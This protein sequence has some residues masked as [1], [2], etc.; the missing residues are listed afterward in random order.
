M[1]EDKN[2]PQMQSMQSLKIGEYVIVFSVEAGGRQWYLGLV[3]HIYED[4]SI[5]VNHFVP[6]RC[7]IS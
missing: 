7:Q 5:S 6:E 1:F 4:G 2:N 3:D